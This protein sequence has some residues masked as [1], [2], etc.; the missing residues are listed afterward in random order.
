MS[1]L[2]LYVGQVGI[3]TGMT[4]SVDKDRFYP[5]AD[6]SSIDMVAMVAVVTD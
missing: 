3:Q 4:I 2:H 1:G 6:V 5:K